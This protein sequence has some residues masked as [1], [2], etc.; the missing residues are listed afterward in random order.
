[1]DLATFGI[2]IGLNVG[3]SLLGWL[4]GANKQ[5]PWTQ[6]EINRLETFDEP[7][8][9]YGEV[10]PRCYGKV[11][12]NGIYAAAQVPFDWERD[13][14]RNGQTREFELTYIYYGNLAVI[15]A[16]KP[17]ISSSPEIK[18]IFFNKRTYYANGQV[19]GLLGQYWGRFE[20][21]TVNN[22]YGDQTTND[23][24]L[25]FLGDKHTAFKNTV[26]S[27]MKRLRLNNSDGKLFDFRYPN[28]EAEFHTHNGTLYLSEV[29][30]DLLD[31][32]GYAAEEYDVTELA[33][34]PCL[35]FIAEVD[36]LANKL[37]QLQ[38]A[39]FFEIV[40]TGA[41]LKF[42][43]QFRP[44]RVATINYGDLGGSDDD[45][46]G[47][48]F[49]ESE[50]EL[51]SL[52]TSVRILYNNYG[53]DYQ[54]ASKESFKI[55]LGD[56]ENVEEVATTLTLSE[57]DAL[58]IVN[59][60]LL[61]AWTRRKRYKFS[62]LPRFQY[63]EAGD[64]IDVEFREG[65]E[66]TQ[67]QIAKLNQSA[68][69]LIEI[70]G[71]GYDGT[72]FDFG[73]TMPSDN[74]TNA[75]ITQGVAIPL[76]QENIYAVNTVTNAGGTVTYTEG[77]DYTVDTVSGTVTPII[78]GGITNGSD[79]VVN[80]QGDETIP[81]P[82]VETP[83]PTTLSGFNTVRPFLE[84]DFGLYLLADG[85]IPWQSAILWASP[86]GSNY[87]NRGPIYRGAFGTCAT[88]LPDGTGTD[89]TSTLTVTVS[90]TMTLPSSGRILV[91]AEI[92]DYSNA[93]LDATTAT[94]KTYTLSQFDRALRDT[95]GTGHGG[96]EYFALLSGYKFVYPVTE[97]DIGNTYYFKAVSPGQTLNDVS[98]ISLTVAV[99]DDNDS[100]KW[101]G[102]S[103]EISDQ[104]DLWSILQ[105]TRIWTYL[106]AG[107]TVPNER[108]SVNVQVDQD[109]GFGIGVPVA[110]FRQSYIGDPNAGGYAQL[111][112][113]AVTTNESGIFL[114]LE[115]TDG[116][117]TE[118]TFLT[119]DIIIPIYAGD[120]SIFGGIS[121]LL[122]DTGYSTGD[123]FY[124]GGAAN[125]VEVD[126]IFDGGNAGTTEFESTLDASNAS[127]AFAWGDITGTLSNQT[128]L[129]SALDAIAAGGAAWG[130]I[131][132]TLSSQTDLNNALN[133]KFDNPVGTINQYIRG[134][135]S[136]DTFPSIPTLT[137]DLT[138]D[139]GFI[140]GISWGNIS[141]TLSNQTDLQTALDSKIEAVPFGGFIEAIADKT[142]PLFKPDR[143]YL[144][145]SLRVKSDSGT[146]TWA[147]QIGG[148]DV[149]GL[150][151]VSVSSVEQLVSATGANTI[152]AGSRVT[153]VS[154]NNSSA[155]DVEFTIM[156][157]AI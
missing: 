33:D 10:I 61:L 27:S 18:K 48:L 110:V 119:G 35:G 112:C 22:Y 156:L 141:G 36:T 126:G 149:T 95:D 45:K 49:T 103:G 134:D 32:A 4:F 91:G 123:T 68:S 29:V 3:S 2:G 52:P 157:E 81:A 72:I 116:I 5:K 125:T 31:G 40:D 147:I 44:S 15:W 152:N 55:K 92:L 145:K 132:G 80:W 104:S 17:R 7:Q 124:D 142:Y 65:V 100:G 37:E 113:S 136:L 24:I 85:D 76:G 30:A 67:V 39:Y 117:V 87:T 9:R 77:V 148:V 109:F 57:A 73:F 25:S 137:S 12:V 101:G 62:I 84:D 60:Q 131:T 111:S 144:L 120:V 129:Q 47:D 151:A 94:T 135:G 108:E 59:K 79:V 71:V 46:S 121:K 130:G 78:G 20:G 138:N 89:N 143:S 70:E 99:T 28:L 133:N 42:I 118:T 74:T 105:R 19:D 75:T 122:S 86:D 140:T 146:C 115:N 21:L 64:V 155:V 69:G 93:A 139:S 97:S 96:S 38:T 6:R 26:Y 107:F 54:P 56:W 98:P 82:S 50:E 41:Q 43:K 106:S 16:M 90:E 34:V 11:R 83:I 66:P 128:D 88:T 150:G 1:M 8:S 51:T 63:L 13:D 102:I 153:I 58:N 127:L 154:T 114:T 14:Y 23:P 53:D